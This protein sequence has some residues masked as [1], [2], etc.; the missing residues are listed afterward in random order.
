M[1]QTH[2]VYAAALPVF[3][4]VRAVEPSGCQDSTGGAPSASIHDFPLRLSRFVSFSSPFAHF[5]SFIASVMFP[6]CV[7]SYFL[8]FVSFFT[9]FLLT[10]LL[11]DLARQTLLVSENKPRP[12]KAVFVWSCRQRLTAQINYSLYYF[13]LF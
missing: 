7:I 9:R 4:R 1:R 3:D 8:S 11:P 13:Y 10:P 12:P 6:F 2:C 5:L